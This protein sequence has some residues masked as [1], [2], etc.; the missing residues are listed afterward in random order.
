MADDTA[1]GDFT[2][3]YMY[4]VNVKIITSEPPVFKQKLLGSLIRFRYVS[5]VLKT[6]F[7]PLCTNGISHNS[8]WARRGHLAPPKDPPGV[9]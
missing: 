7:N 1:C 6:A 4:T 2:R 9:V 5:H 3:L 8:P